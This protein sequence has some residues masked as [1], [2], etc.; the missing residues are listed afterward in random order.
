MKSA[1]TGHTNHGSIRLCKSCAHRCRKPEAHGA[2]AA[3]GDHR[4]GV[5]ICVVLSSPHLMLSYVGDDNSISICDLRDRTAPLLGVGSL[6]TLRL[7]T[8]LMFRLGTN[9]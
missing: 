2:E 6:L 4:T 5:V 8:R 1:I 9:G 7:H 3:R